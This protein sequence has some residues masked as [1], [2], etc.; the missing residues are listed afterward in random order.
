MD[1]TPDHLINF[2]THMELR[3]KNK[4]TIDIRDEINVAK[5]GGTL[6]EKLGSSLRF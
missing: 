2:N 4:E 1:L 5:G 3:I 6:F